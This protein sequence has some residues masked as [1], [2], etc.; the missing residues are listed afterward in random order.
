MHLMMSRGAS[1][2]ER[3]AAK[4][5]QSSHFMPQDVDEIEEAL[6]GSGVDIISAMAV[7]WRC[8]VFLSQRLILPLRRPKSEK[9]HLFRF[10]RALPLYPF[11]IWG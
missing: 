5:N 7:C 8:R 11:G 9:Y 1:Y 6:D 3:Q 10:T 2:K 4:A